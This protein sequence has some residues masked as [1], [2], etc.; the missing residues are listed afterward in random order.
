[1]PLSVKDYHR[2]QIFRKICDTKKAEN[3]LLF[4]LSLKL[5]DG[6]KIQKKGLL[7]TLQDGNHSFKQNILSAIWTQG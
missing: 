3:V 7:P 2:T 4:Y 1:M 6:K 5:H